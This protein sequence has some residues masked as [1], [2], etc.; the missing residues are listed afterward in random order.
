MPVGSRT[1]TAP[2]LPPRGIHHRDAYGP[3][4]RDGQGRRHV[5]HLRHGHGHPADDVKGSQDVDGAAPARDDRHPRLDDG[6]RAGVQQPCVGARRHP[7][8][9]ALVDGLQLLDVWQERLS[10]RP[11]EQP[12]AAL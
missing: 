7:V 1:G 4:S 2:R 6:L 10:H 12:L 3:R 11:A 5:L 8:A 9:R